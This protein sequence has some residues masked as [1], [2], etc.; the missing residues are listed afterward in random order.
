[1]PR[2]ARLD[3]PELVHHVMARGIEGCDIFR[4]DSDK[5]SF[6]LRLSDVIDNGAKASLYAWTL[7]SNHFHILMRLE[8]GVRLS[9]LMQRLLTGYS[10]NFNKL[11]KRKGHLFQNRYKNIVVDEEPYFLELLRYIH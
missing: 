3:V 8:K 10:V 6:L 9:N 11:H 4:N 1:M 2:S 5:H 7:M